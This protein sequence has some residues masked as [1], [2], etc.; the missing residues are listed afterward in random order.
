LDNNLLFSF[1]N[2]SSFF[3][4]I[5]NS[6]SRLFFGFSVSGSGVGVDVGV[7]VDDEDCLGDL[8]LK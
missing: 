6:F 4:N 1:F 5:S 2:S 8:N 7:G 3:V